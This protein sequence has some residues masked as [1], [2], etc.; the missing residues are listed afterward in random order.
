MILRLRSSAPIVGAMTSNGAPVQPSADSM[1]VELNLAT[2]PFGNRRLFWMVYGMAAVVLVVLAGALVFQY[3]RNYDAAPEVVRREAALR[4]DLARLSS[5]ESQLR[6]T[7]QDPANAPVLERSM[8]LNDLLYRKGISWT[9]T[10]AD[11]EKVLPPRVLMMSIRPE[12]TV[13]NKV[14]LEMQVGAETPQDFLEFMR[15]L[16]SSELFGPPGMSTIA[17]P[18]ENEPLYRYQVTVNY[19]QRL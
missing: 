19:E 11:L 9:Q 17:P 12:V 3:S 18:N 5:T 1:Q 8:F 14:R 7:L 2:Q 16:E 13:E 15:T 6:R 10:F 4:A